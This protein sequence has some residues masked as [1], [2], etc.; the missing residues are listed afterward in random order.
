[1]ETIH[2]S[3]IETGDLLA[4][5]RNAHSPVSD[6]I[7]R[8]IAWATRNEFG[9]VGVAWKLRDFIEDELFCFEATIPFVDVNRVTEDRHFYCIKTGVKMGEAEKR[10]LLSFLG[11]PYGYMDALRALF[12]I[13]VEEGGNI[14]CAELC[15]IFYEQCGIMLPREY[16]PSD[17]ICNMLLATNNKLLRVVTS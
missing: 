13:P 1:M 11:R 7:I 15:H 10:L 2:I 9:H 14:Q 12:G 5:S 6:L 4:W 16:R 17:I 8:M 3:E